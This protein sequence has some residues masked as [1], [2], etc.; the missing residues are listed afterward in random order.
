MGGLGDVPTPADYNGD[1]KAEPPHWLLEA[2]WYLR[3]SGTGA[4]A[5][6]QWGGWGDAPAP[7]DYNGD[8]IADI[9]VFRRSDG[10]WYLRVLR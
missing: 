9:V 4:T 1:G 7:A 3:Y 2:V 6:I 5:N 8:G 10:V